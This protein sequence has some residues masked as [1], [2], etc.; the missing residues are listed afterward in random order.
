MAHLPKEGLMS[1]EMNEI[2]C[3]DD[4]LYTPMTC[5]NY[6]ENLKFDPYPV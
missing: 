4:A 3:F 5:P 2:S 6:G 1:K